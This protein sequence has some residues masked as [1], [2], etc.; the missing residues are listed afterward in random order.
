MIIS[1]PKSNFFD[2]NFQKLSHIGR[3]GF[4]EVYHVRH[5]IEGEEYAVKIVKFLDIYGDNKRQEILKEV[6]NLVKLRS[7][8]VVNY[9]NSWRED[10]HLYIQMDYYPQNLQTIIDNKHIVF[11][12]QTGEPMKIFEYFISCEIIRELLE[13]V[14]YLHDLCPPVIHRDLKPS[15]VMISQ[16]SNNNRFIRLCDLGLATS[17]DMTSM[18]H[19][20]NVG[21]AQYMAPEIFQP[22]YTIKV[23]IYSLAVEN[24]GRNEGTE[25]KVSVGEEGNTPKERH[26]REERNQSHKSRDIQSDRTNQ[27]STRVMSGSAAGG[28]KP[29][30]FKGNAS[31]LRAKFE[32]MAQNEEMVVKRR[33]DEERDRRLEREKHEMT[34]EKERQQVV[35]KSAANPESDAQK[36]K[37]DFG[38]TAKPSNNSGSPTKLTATALYDYKAVDLD[39]I[40]LDMNELI[41]DIEMMDEGW[42]RGRCGN[43]VGLFPTIVVIIT[44]LWSPEMTVSTDGVVIVTDSWDVE[45]STRLK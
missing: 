31:K 44:H 6:Q 4:G 40:N 23:D 7:D 32:S 38:K 14:K 12:R 17:H 24:M 33:A 8:F 25:G 3:G 26:K 28:D 10:N 13:S 19:T 35:T 37:P 34:A 41:T 39:G 9:R 43:K 16:N 22:R 36:Q 42:C 11:G 18:S 29:T 20:S 27:L 5:M 45:N 1:N 15:N 2:D 21:T 30:V